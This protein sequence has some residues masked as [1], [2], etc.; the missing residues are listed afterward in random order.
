MNRRLKFIESGKVQKLKLPESGK[1]QKLKLP[2]KLPRLRGIAESIVHLDDGPTFFDVSLVSNPPDHSARIFNSSQRLYENW[3]LKFQQ[4]FCRNI[5]CGSLRQI[6]KTTTLLR[7][8]IEYVNL[9]DNRQIVL[10]TPNSIIRNLLRNRVNSSVHIITEND[11]QALT[12]LQNYILFAD[13]CPN[14]HTLRNINGEFI[15]GFYSREF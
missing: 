13:E 9:N 15:A 8:L 5:N 4:G 14:A 3:Q 6:G 10:M 2:N 7:I 12:G 1:V 11:R